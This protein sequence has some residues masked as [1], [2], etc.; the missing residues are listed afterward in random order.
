AGVPCHP[1][2]AKPSQLMLDPP[3]TPV[4]VKEKVTLTCR[5][6][7]VSGPT[8]WYRNRQIWDQTASNHTH[9]SEARIG[10]SSYQC[11]SPGTELSTP[12][13]LSFSND[14]LVLQVPTGSLLEG[15]RALL[16]CRS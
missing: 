5:G 15:D 4:F 3:W 7:G 6:S 8:Y 14:W 12:V 9:V 16:R 10:S 11:C 1:A 13:T 2:G